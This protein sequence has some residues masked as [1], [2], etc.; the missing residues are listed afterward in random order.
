[1]IEPL[2]PAELGQLLR[3]LR[4]KLGL[5]GSNLHS[6]LSKIY[7]TRGLRGAPSLATISRI[8]SGLRKQTSVI[9]LEIF[10]EALGVST[11]EFFKTPPK[12][13]GDSN[14]LHYIESIGE[15]SVLYSAPA[16]SGDEFHR[17]ERIIST[18][19]RFLL[20]M[21]SITLDA[22][23]PQRVIRIFKRVHMTESFTA[24]ISM[25]IH[26]LLEM[27]GRDPDLRCRNSISKM[28]ANRLTKEDVFCNERHF[29]DAF[30]WVCSRIEIWTLNATELNERDMLF[31]MYLRNPCSYFCVAS[32]GKYPTKAFWS[33][34]DSR[35]GSFLSKDTDL[36]AETFEVINERRT[37]MSNAEVITIDLFRTDLASIRENLRAQWRIA[38]T[39]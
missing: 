35:E 31:Q 9:Q 23:S 32:S 36:I 25:R 18:Y 34:G 3:S 20:K 6:R 30:N 7:E 29:I 4:K 26:W 5:T 33:F 17:S 14:L 38:V 2:P 27:R 24:L 15:A 22:P 39:S 10:A 13:D 8:E 21:D 19:F 12:S 16:A 28:Y 37:G 1:M 11:S